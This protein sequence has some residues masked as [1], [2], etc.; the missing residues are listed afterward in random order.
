MSDYES[1]AGTAFRLKDV[2]FWKESPCVAR[3]SLS[4]KS[5]KG[6]AQA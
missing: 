4:Q 6:D 3:G 2:S 5:E 1:K